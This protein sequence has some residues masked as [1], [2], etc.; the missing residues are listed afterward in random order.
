VLFR[1]RAR[2]TR[3]AVPSLLALLA[4]AGCAGAPDRD[5][6]T[7]RIRHVDIRTRDVFSD[8][9]AHGNLLYRAANALHG[10]TWP[11]VVERELWFGEGDVVDRADVEEL[12]RRL[13][14]TGWFGAVDTELVPVP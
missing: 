6:D 3:R 12:A 13:R 1:S 14:G 11:H 8:E 5:P 7:Y 4:C 10:T 9:A 2:M